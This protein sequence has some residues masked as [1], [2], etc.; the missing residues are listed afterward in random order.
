M[1][2][3][4]DQSIPMVIIT[5]LDWSNSFTKSVL[6]LKF[7]GFATCVSLV[8]AGNKCVRPRPFPRIAPPPRPTPSSP[9]QVQR[10]V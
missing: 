3:F 1:S 10:S 5:Q 6:I 9:G 7:I 2:E 4:T 8:L